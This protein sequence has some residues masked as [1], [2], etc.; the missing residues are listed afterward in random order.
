MSTADPLLFRSRSTVPRRTRIKPLAFI[1]E[2][3]VLKGTEEDD[4]DDEGPVCAASLERKAELEPLLRRVLAGKVEALGPDHPNAIT[5]LSNL[6]GLLEELGQT[7]EA[8]HLYREALLRREE[9]LGLT[10]N[11]TLVSV[12]NL[13]AFLQAMERLEEAEQLHRRALDG[14][15]QAK[16]SHPQSRACADNFASLLEATGRQSEAEAILGSLGCI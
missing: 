6:A 7:E 16:A 10:H 1:S 5:S 3:M 9:T 15:R 12:S 13:A 8:E 14:F 2:L 4:D 11:D